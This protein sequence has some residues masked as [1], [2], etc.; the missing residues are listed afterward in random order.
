MK[1]ISIVLM[2]TGVFLFCANGLFA[3]AIGLKIGW[4]KMLDEYADAE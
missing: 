2:I 1:K 3:D 4:N